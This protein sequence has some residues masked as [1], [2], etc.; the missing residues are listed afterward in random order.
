MGVIWQVL[1]SNTYSTMGCDTSLDK[2]IRG[3][4]WRGRSGCAERERSGYVDGEVDKREE[5]G[6][7]EEREGGRGREGVKKEEVGEVGPEEEMK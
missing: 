3:G 7:V 2:S 5:V 6:K 4:L 1:T